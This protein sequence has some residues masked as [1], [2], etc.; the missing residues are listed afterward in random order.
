MFTTSTTSSTTTTAPTTVPPPSVPTTT[1]TTVPS[2]PLANA[3]WRF[4]VRITT[5]DPFPHNVDVPAHSTDAPLD[6]MIRADHLPAFRPGDQMTGPEIAALGGDTLERLTA[7]VDAYLRSQ[8]ADYPGFGTIVE[9][10][11]AERIE[12]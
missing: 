4:Y 2:P 11:W 9:V 1:T 10:R 3:S 8:A 6:V 7:A 5:G 12:P